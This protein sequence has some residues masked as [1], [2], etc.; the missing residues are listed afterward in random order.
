MAAETAAGFERMIV[1]A[2]MNLNALCRPAKRAAMMGALAGAVLFAST[3][4]LAGEHVVAMKNMGADGA[5][6]FEPAYVAAQVGDTVRFVP[7]DK[8]HNAAPIDGMVPSG[9]KLPVGAIN[10]EYVVKL[11][12]P[13]LYGIKCTPHYGMGMIALIKAGA[14]KAPNAAQANAAAAKIPPLAAKRMKPLL[15]KAK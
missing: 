7:T 11:T 4:A 8:S 15:V 13:G 10:A 3:P 5:M 1:K 14:G 9:I 2:F 6:V 12:K